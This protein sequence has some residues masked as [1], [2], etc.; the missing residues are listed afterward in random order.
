MPTCLKAHAL[1]QQKPLQWKVC[2]LQ[3]QNSPPCSLI[4][5]LKVYTLKQ[6]KRKYGQKDKEPKH[7]KA[8]LAFNRRIFSH[9]SLMKAVLLHAAVCLCQGSWGSCWPLWFSGQPGFVISDGYDFPIV[10]RWVLWFSLWNVYP[11][12][13]SFYFNGSVRVEYSI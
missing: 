11:R 1:Y 5:S 13:N 9:C 3:L 2:A 12:I 7:S 6:I 4:N 10:V 8:S